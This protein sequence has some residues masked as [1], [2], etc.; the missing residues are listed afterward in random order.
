MGT[1]VEMGFLSAVLRTVKSAE[2]ITAPSHR[3]RKKTAYDQLGVA[4]ELPRHLPAAKVQCCSREFIEL[5]RRT[6]Q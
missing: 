4:T 5:F 6:V 2:P 1:A 3:W